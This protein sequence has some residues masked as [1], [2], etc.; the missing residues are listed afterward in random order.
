MSAA[1]Q[2]AQAYELSQ[3]LAPY[4]D[5]HLVLPILEYNQVSLL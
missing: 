3:K 5:A 4:L 1:A 2:L